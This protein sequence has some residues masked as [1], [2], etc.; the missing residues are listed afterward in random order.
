MPSLPLPFLL[1][2]SPPPTRGK[3]AI[4]LVARRPYRITPAHAGKSPTI[5]TKPPT[6]RDHPRP[7]GEKTFAYYHD[8]TCTGSPPPTRGKDHGT[9][10]ELCVVRITPAHAGKRLHISFRLCPFE[11]HPR[12][13][14]EK[15]VSIFKKRRCVGSPPP[16]RGKVAREETQK[17]IFGITPAHAGKRWSL[18]SAF[19]CNQDHP[20]PRGEKTYAAH[21]S[22][23]V[24]GSPPPTRGKVS[25]IAFTPPTERITPAHAGKRYAHGH[26]QVG[27]QD[28]PR[29]RGEKFSW[30]SDATFQPGS[31]PPTRG[32]AV[33]VVC[34]GG[35]HG[36]TPAHAGKRVLFRPPPQ[37]S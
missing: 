10:L 11:D 1:Q 37:Y 24:L 5:S 2:G 23:S 33:K 26:N 18:S 13:R 15:S 7:R 19:T 28:H 4:L 9:L 22:I 31:P 30:P 20:R 21:H 35:E 3:A 14:G 6:S 34:D 25:A 27:K 17:A 12:P 16:T 29:P 36:I 32:K 8:S